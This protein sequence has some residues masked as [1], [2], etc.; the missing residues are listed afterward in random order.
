MYDATQRVLVGVL[1]GLI[2][3]TSALAQNDDDKW[4]P[5]SYLKS[6]YRQVRTVAR[7]NNRPA[8]NVNRIGGY[9]DWHLLRE[10]VVPFEGKVRKGEP[11]DFYPRAEKCFHR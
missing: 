5:L 11:N 2:A 7:V 9:R 6:D 10:V 4:P 3:A 8:E 1:F